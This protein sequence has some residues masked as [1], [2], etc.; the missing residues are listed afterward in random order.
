VDVRPENEGKE[1]SRRMD[2]LGRLFVDVVG[3]YGVHPS[4]S[5]T[6]FAVQISCGHFQLGNEY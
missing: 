5:E 4:L 2:E 3:V 1:G 6:T